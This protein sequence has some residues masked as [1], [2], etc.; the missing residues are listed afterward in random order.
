MGREHLTALK[1][2]LLPIVALFS[3][4]LAWSIYLADRAGIRLIPTGDDLRCPYCGSTDVVKVK[5]WDMP[6]QGYHVTR[7][8]CRSCGNAFNQ[9]AERSSRRRRKTPLTS[10]QLF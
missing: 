8:V 1:Y 7:Y 2:L 9:A 10:E 6:K 5:E 3:P 4:E